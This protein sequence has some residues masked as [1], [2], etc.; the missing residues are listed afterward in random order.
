MISVICPVYNDVGGLKTTVESLI[1]QDFDDYEIIIAD[2]NS[3]D[4]TLE[5]ALS[6]AEHN[7]YIELT[8]EDEIQSSY[9]NRN[10]A[11][12]K[13]RGDIIAFIDADMNVPVDWLSSLQKH[14]DK[15]DTE[16]LGC[17]VILY[18]PENVNNYSAWYNI[19]TGFPIENYIKHSHYAPTCCLSVRSYVFNKNGLFD[20]RL[21]S[22]GDW[23]FGQRC[24]DYGIKQRYDPFIIMYHPAK[25]SYE[26]LKKKYTRI[27]RGFYQTA[28]NHPERENRLYKNLK[29]IPMKTLGKPVIDPAPVSSS[30]IYKLG[31]TKDKIIFQLID[32]SLK[33]NII[34]GYYKE[35]F[36]L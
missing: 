14:F 20:S 13:S 24:Y 35:K 19:A 3:N 28:K 1:K 21:I 36:G 10:R 22:C 8:I 30:D 4:G 23:E 27:G 17:N 25:T 29:N 2:N 16:Y 6:Y 12:R 5:L 18:P 33:L 34:K 26:S 15:N 7:P 9:A 11:I 31:D 32:K